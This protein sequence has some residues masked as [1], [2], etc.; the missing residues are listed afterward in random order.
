M[1]P[2]DVAPA[3]WDPTRYLDF[4]GERLRPL[5]DLLHR[6]PLRRAER[7]VDLGCGTGV[8]L[9]PLVR[10]FPAA[11]IEALDSSAAMLERARALCHEDA[12]GVGLAGADI[13]LQL[14]DIAS[15]SD[16]ESDD[17]RDGG[18]RASQQP[19]RE[20]R[21]PG[22]DLVFS[23]A[24][25]HWLG[26]HRELLPALLRRV[27]PGGVLAIQMPNNWA[28]PSHAAMRRVL[29]TLGTPAAAATLARLER[30]PGDDDSDYER[31]LAP[32]RAH[33]DSWE[34]EYLQRLR[35]AP[36]GD[37][38]DAPET[39]R[40]A[41]FEWVRST[42]LRPV[43]AALAQDPAAW[44]TFCERYDALLRQ[45]YPSRDDGI[46]PFPFRRLFLVAVRSGGS[47]A[48]DSEGP[49]EPPRR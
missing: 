5:L 37:Q 3:D 31:W 16:E 10:R 24:A 48:T 12:E 47:S 46:T 8:A 40:S 32:H 1:S 11:R 45:A 27:R 43:E 44:R 30:R 25:L 34:S 33:L 23:N 36:A 2:P 49:R 15:W 35:A 18:G 14:A 19:P 22:F 26:G 38:G 4:A 20:Q 7:I 41:V 28:A 17:G 21:E 6:V 29:A 13:H 9:A 39:T 42:A